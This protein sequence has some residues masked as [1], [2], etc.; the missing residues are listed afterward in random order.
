MIVMK[1]IFGM[2]VILWAHTVL[3]ADIYL[4]R[5][6]RRTVENGVESDDALEVNAEP[7]K[8]FRTVCILGK[9]KLTFR[10]VLRPN[11]NEN[12]SI[13]FTFSDQTET[14]TLKT[15]PIET[16]PIYSP[17]SNYRTTVTV[18]VDSPTTFGD[19]LSSDTDANGKHERQETCK[20]RIFRDEAK[21]E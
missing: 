2:L 13:D 8:P 5:V 7:G 4:V 19:F 15:S 17:Q 3:A 12:F 9:R 1:T 10:G 21:P 16:A 14:A 18:S 20:L 6:E 11:E